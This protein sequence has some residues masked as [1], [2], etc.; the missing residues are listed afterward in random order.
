MASSTGSWTWL[1][2]RNGLAMVNPHLNP[3]SVVTCLTHDC[4]ACLIDRIVI[5]LARAPRQLVK[6]LTAHEL[7]R[8]QQEAAG[9]LPSTRPKQAPTAAACS[10]VLLLNARIPTR[11]PAAKTVTR[12]QVVGHRTRLTCLY[13]API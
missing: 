5:S 12:C 7:G 2:G 8:L 13:I 3:H 10:A 6:A 4:L 1:V 9:E 11:I